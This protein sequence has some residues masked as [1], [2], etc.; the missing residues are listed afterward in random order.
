MENLTFVTGLKNANGLEAKWIPYGTGGDYV[1]SSS[2]GNIVV[3]SHF[4]DKPNWMYN[5]EIKKRFS[6]L[7]EDCQNWLLELVKEPFRNIG[8]ENPLTRKLSKFYYELT[9][10]GIYCYS[11]WN[12]G[13]NINDVRYYLV[14]EGIAKLN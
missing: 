2:V 8:D 4:F 1:V 11:S 9:W 13:I 12:S 6:E 7:S 3:Y 5:S 14:N 10:T